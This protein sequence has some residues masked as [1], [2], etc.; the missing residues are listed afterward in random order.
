MYFDARSI[1]TMSGRLTQ[2]TGDWNVRGHGN[3]TGGGMGFELEADSGEELELMVAPAWFL[4]ENG[5]VLGDGERITTT[6]S[7]IEE[8]DNGNHHGGGP[9]HGGSAL[10][11]MMSGDDEGYP[12][13]RGGPGW[14]GHR[15]FDPDGLT[16]MTGTLNELQGLWSAWGQGNH[17]G[18]GMHYTFDSDGGESF[19]AM[20]GPWWFMKG[21]GLKL[22]DGKRV[23]IRG[24]IVESYWPKYDDR[25]FIVA[26]EIKIGSKT[27]RLRDDWGYP[28]WHGTG[29]HYTSPEWATSS[30]SNLSGE[31]VKIQRRKNGRFLDRGFELVM[32]IQGQDYRLFVAPVWDVKY[33]GL[34]LHIGD[35]VSARGSMIAGAG[36]PKMVVQ[37]LDANGQRWNFRRRGGIPMWVQGAK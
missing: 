32:R 27:A 20:V 23:E 24:A 37:Y 30:M 11:G 25:R 35:R 2:D 19:Y 15:W 16:T 7:L 36:R 29:W 26:T 12:L 1:V 33:M 22:A 18:N 17:T 3:H 13:W 31:I 8:Y 34:K 21:Q 5:I 14:T 10:G 28:L 4:E 9:G 6:G